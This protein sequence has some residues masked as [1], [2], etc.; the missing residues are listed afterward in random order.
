MA[1][2]NPAK[3]ARPRERRT[4][5]FNAYEARFTAS[6]EP[7]DEIATLEPGRDRTFASII[8]SVVIN[9]EPAQRPAVEAKLLGVLGNAKCTSEGRMFVCRMLA[10]IG[11]AKS[12]P[13]LAPLLTA[14]ATA[15]VARYA[16]DAIPDRAVDAEYRAALPKLRGA[17]KAGLIGSIG[18]RG[19]REAA[20]PLGAIASDAS[21]SADVRAAAKRA[22]ERLNTSAA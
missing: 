3:A 17:A 11:S 5:E 18:L 20:A 12:V 8:R 1:D 10:L 16:L 6:P 13:A 21:E 7:W 22:I 14:A 9:A 2:T 15:D 4:S 19:D